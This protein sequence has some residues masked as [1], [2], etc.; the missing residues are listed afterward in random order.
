LYGTGLAVKNITMK[1]NEY[2]LIRK[3]HEDSQQLDPSAVAIDK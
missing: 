3:G 2:G 1:R